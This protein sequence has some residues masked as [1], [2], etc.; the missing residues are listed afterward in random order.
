[1]KSPMGTITSSEEEQASI[2][3]SRL[4]VMLAGLLM[5][6]IALGMTLDPSGDKHGVAAGLMA[7]LM[8]FTLV[9]LL[10]WWWCA[11]KGLIFAS[12]VM[13]IAFM[14]SLGVGLEWWHRPVD[15]INL[16][17]E[18]ASLTGRVVMAEAMT[19]NRKR[20][21]V[22]PDHPSRY[23]QGNPMADLRLITAKE[24]MVLKPGDRI[25]GE[26]RLNKPLPRL[27]PGSFDFTAHARSQ[28]YAG[29]GFIKNVTIIGHQQGAVVP[30]LRHAIQQRFAEHL[31]EDQAAIASAV[32]VGL[33]AGIK[34]EFCE[35]FRASGLAHLLAIS[36][37]HMALFWGSVVALIRGGLALFPHF[38]SR[39]P[40]LKIATLGAMPFGFFYLMISGQPISAVRVFLML[41]LVMVAILLTR[42]GVTQHHVALVALGILIFSP[43]SLVHPAFQ[44]SFAAV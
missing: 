43:H 28:N 32:I 24:S 17:A 39:Y 12:R 7:G 36:G 37:L 34:P 40:S 4:S 18:E 6:G 26:M 22:H 23:W 33:R 1:M 13:M 35:D 3:P 15:D 14:L 25:Q 42:R 44:M 41:A 19:N 8:G 5:L 21:R 9:N 20:L 2:K 16:T 30:Q 11:Q 27:L 10:V 29:H 31:T 38:S